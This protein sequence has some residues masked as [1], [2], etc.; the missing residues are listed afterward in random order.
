MISYYNTLTTW[1]DVDRLLSVFG[2]TREALANEQRVLLRLAGC[3]E[4]QGYLFARP[5]PRDEIDRL[6]RGGAPAPLRA[7][8]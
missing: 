5:G 7:S 2:L 6:L 1:V 4:M 8:A 3:S